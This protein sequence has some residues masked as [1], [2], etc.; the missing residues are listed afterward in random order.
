MG[1]KGVGFLLLHCTGFK[2]W[3]LA[4]EVLKLISVM[5][6]LGFYWIGRAALSLPASEHRITI[7]RRHVDRFGAVVR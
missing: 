2:K 6:A 3:G 7:M 1:I 5:E 4:G